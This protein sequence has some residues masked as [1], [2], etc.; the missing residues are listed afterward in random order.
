MSVLDSSWSQW[1]LQVTSQKMGPCMCMEKKLDRYVLEVWEINLFLDISMDSIWFRS[2][3]TFSVF[4]FLKIYIASAP[5][6]L[7]WAI[8]I[9]IVDG[10]I[11]IAQWKTIRKINPSSKDP[12]NL[13]FNQLGHMADFTKKT[14]FGMMLFWLFYIVDVANRYVSI[15]K[16]SWGTPF[17]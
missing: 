3:N 15:R 6:A 2:M 8:T 11:F 9:T 7:C 17:F 16:S 5:Y 4:F 12:V 13:H 14:Q 1:D 10:N